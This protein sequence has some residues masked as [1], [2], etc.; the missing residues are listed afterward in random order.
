MLSSQIS[1]SNFKA[2]TAQSSTSVPGQVPHIISASTTKYTASA[3]VVSATPPPPSTHQTSQANERSIAVQP[4]S[5]KIAE[6]SEPCSENKTKNNVEYTETSHS[7]DDDVVE[8]TVQSP[9]NSTKS[10]TMYD[11]HSLSSLNF[12][13]SSYPRGRMF[14]GIPTPLIYLMDA[15]SSLLI[16]LR[17]RRMS[18]ADFKVG[19]IIGKGGQSIVLKA[20]PLP[21]SGIWMVSGGMVVLRTAFKDKNCKTQQLQLKL[22]LHIYEQ[23]RS[24][25]NIVDCFGLVEEP[26]NHYLVLEALTGGDVHR[27]TRTQEARTEEFATTVGIAV[28]KALCALHNAGFAH[29]DVKP[30]NIMLAKKWSFLSVNPPAMKLID[31]GLACSWNPLKP[32]TAVSSTRCGTWGFVA[33]EVFTDAVYEVRNADIY[34]VGATMY[35]AIAGRSPLQKVDGYKRGEEAAAIARLRNQATPF[36]G[37]VWD[38]VS[39]ESKEFILACTDFCPNRRPTAWEGLSWLKNIESSRQAHQQFGFRLSQSMLSDNR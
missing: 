10:S 16:S 18:L 32:E 19:E 30:G 9:S 38:N 29:R 24:H 15:I 6:T 20:E 21:R 28:L 22:T 17:L 2:V 39:I 1:A 8:G 12:E 33:P 13:N 11:I 4:I 34:S 36:K 25:P 37:D 14:F 3:D 31:F 7:S 5:S 26:D 27:I 23:I 35:Y